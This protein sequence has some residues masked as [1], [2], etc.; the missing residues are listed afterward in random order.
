M[1]AMVAIDGVLGVNRGLGLQ[2]LL[3]PLDVLVEQAKHSRA[4][5]AHLVEVI[6]RVGTLDRDFVL[7]HYVLDL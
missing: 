2:L 5:I 6:A 4:S 1:L 7:G 3:L